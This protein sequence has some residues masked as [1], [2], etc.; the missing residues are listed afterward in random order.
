[1][2]NDV[3]LFASC[4]AIVCGLIALFTLYNIYRGVN[5]NLASAHS[6][7][8]YNFRYLQPLTGEYERYLAKVVNIR[9]LDKFE[10]GR[11]NF[12]SNY[13][14][15]DK[16]FQRS[17]TLVTCQMSNGDYRQFYAERSDMA[18]RSAIGGLLF[19]AGVAHL[20]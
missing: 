20:F 18:R 16:D 3:L 1:M 13:R 19:K 5:G 4:F 2:M 8:V 6:G 15:Y 12:T 11:L 14:V 10:L 7:D 17:P 9:K